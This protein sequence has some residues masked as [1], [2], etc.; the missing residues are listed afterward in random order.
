LARTADKPTST[1][2]AARAI[3]KIFFMFLY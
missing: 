3:N 2:R 1:A